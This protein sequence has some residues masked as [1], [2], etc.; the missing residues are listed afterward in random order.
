[1]PVCLRAWLAVLDPLDWD[2]TREAL[3]AVSRAAAA[4]VLVLVLLLPLASDIALELPVPASLV[5]LAPV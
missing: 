1:M 2:T 4:Q 5:A 3:A